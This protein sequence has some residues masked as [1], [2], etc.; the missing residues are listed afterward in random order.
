[1]KMCEHTGCPRK[2]YAK[3]YCTKHVQRF[4]KHGT[5]ELVVLS[6]E[7]RFKQKFEIHNELHERLGTPC[8]I[9]KA[10]MTLGGYGVFGTKRTTAHR[11][12]YELYIG[13]IP[14]GMVVRHR[15]DNPPCVNPEHLIVGTCKDNTQDSIRRGR[16]SRGETSGAF[17]LTE[18]EVLEISDL[19]N[20]QMTDSSISRQ[21]NVNRQT[22]SNIR[23]G[24]S[25]SWLT[26]RRNN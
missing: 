18:R 9:W 5:S 21:Y 6:T 24:R 14:K 16:H 11:Y 10:G 7:D 4:N 12:S 15:C 20:K 22:V 17:V 26:K 13:K 23:L 19:I 25:W 3:G 1:M 8:W 2:H